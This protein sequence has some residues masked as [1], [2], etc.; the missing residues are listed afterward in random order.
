MAFHEADRGAHGITSSAHVAEHPIAI[1][2]GHRGPLARDHAPAR[3]ERGIPDLVE[4]SFQ[5]FHQLERLAP[6]TA[7]HLDHGMVIERAGD[8]ESAISPSRRDRGW[9]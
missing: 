9:T 7:L 3:V 5:P 6:P 8:V 2:F 4:H 1:G